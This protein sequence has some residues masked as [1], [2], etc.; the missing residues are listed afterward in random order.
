MRKKLRICGEPQSSS[1]LR[2]RSQ[3]NFRFERGNPSL[4]KTFSNFNSAA[5]ETGGKRGAANGENARNRREKC[6]MSSHCDEIEKRRGE[7][8]TA[9][10]T[11]LET[12]RFCARCAEKFGENTIL[13]SLKTDGLKIETASASIQTRKN[14]GGNGF[15]SSVK[16]RKVRCSVAHVAEP[17][18][19][20][21]AAAKNR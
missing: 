9:E 20:R 13:D 16:N 10:N 17:V 3:L 19:R 5:G 21:L 18:F 1:P 4:K 14:L 2:N 12:S 8:S 6:L 15:S 7:N 11:H